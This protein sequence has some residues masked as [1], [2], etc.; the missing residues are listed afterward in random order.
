MVVMEALLGQLHL[1]GTP[2]AGVWAIRSV[3]AVLGVLEGLVA[4]TPPPSVFS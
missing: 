4:S 2:G 3:K 1:S